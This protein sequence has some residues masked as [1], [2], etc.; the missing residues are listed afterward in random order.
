MI[1]H[2]ASTRWRSCVGAGADSGGVGVGRFGGKAAEGGVN[3]DCR[4]SGFVKCEALRK[5]S[6]PY[7]PFQAKSPPYFFSSKNNGHCVSDKY[8]K[9][10][11]PPH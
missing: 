10:L 6:E 9:Q 7:M 2:G 11:H 4:F 1:N 3:F 5:R 8:I